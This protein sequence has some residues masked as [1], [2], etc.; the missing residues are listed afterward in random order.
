MYMAE[1]GLN[2]NW[3]RDYDP[4]TGK[5]VESDPMG[6]KA[7]INTYGYVGQQPTMRIDPT[8]L[9]DCPAGTRRAPGQDFCVED[10]NYTGPPYCPSGDCSVYPPETQCA[11]TQ[12]C[13]KKVIRGGEWGRLTL[14]FICGRATG[15]P[16][17]SGVIC[18]SLV[19]MACGTATR[20][21]CSGCK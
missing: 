14:G 7:G 17:V 8:G 3:N 5:Y 21:K 15:A 2:Q 16:V 20:A 18:Q 1:T 11:F 12:E 9:V 6:L 4:F 13:V 10:P 19:W